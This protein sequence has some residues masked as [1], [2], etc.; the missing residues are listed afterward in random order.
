[1]VTT[2]LFGYNS[3]EILS[4]KE[5][6]TLLSAPKLLVG[7]ITPYEAYQL[8]K[9]GEFG[10]MSDEARSFGF[11][12]KPYW[13]AMELNNS[14]QRRIFLSINNPTLETVDCY[15]YQYGH[16]VE[17]LSD[18][19]FAQQPF[20]KDFSSLES[21]FLL[22]NTT[23][24]TTYLLKIS[25]NN[26]II[27]PML[28][29]ADG[30]IKTV[31]IPEILVFAI[32]TGC[33]LSLFLHNLMLYFS[34]KESDYLLYSAYILC[35]FIL[36]A[37]SR[38]Y[39]SLPIQENIAIKKI[40][41]TLAL[42]ATSISLILFTLKFLNI[43]NLH[44]KI[45][46]TS[47]LISTIC[48]L[49]LMP[50]TFD[51]TWHKIGILSIV[52]LMLLCIYLSIYSYL[53]GY[54]P[55]KHYLLGLFGIFA[56]IFLSILTIHG[57]VAYN[58]FTA[59]APLVSSICGMII[60]SLALGYKVK[61]LQDERN[62]AILRAHM[63]EK[64]LFLQ[65][66]YA[67]MGEMVGNIA[68][69]W[70]SPLNELGAI[71]ANIKASMLYGGGIAREKLITLQELSS[72][73]IKHLSDTIDTFYGFFKYKNNLKS[74]FSIKEELE[75]IQKML[76]YLLDAEHISLQCQID[77]MVLIGNKNEFSH[78]IINI[79]LNAKDAL[80]S[81]EINEPIIS[82][83]AY[84]DGNEYV[85]KISDNAGGIIENPIE[86]IFEPCISSKEDGIGIGLFISR[87]ILEDKMRAKIEVINAKLG[88]IFT[89]RLPLYN[90]TDSSKGGVID[91]M[92]ESVLDRM[93][94]LERKIVIKEEIE[95]MLKQWG[96]VFS[97]AHWGIALHPGTTDCFEMTNSAFEKMH[98][99]SSEELKSIEVPQLI[100]RDLHKVRA[101]QKEAFEKGF[102]SFET[103]SVRKDGTE[104]PVSVDITVV[105]NEIG[106]VL[107]YISNVR[108]ISEQK[109]S[110][111]NLLLK[112]TA[113]NNLKDGVYL[114][115]EKA[116]F[117][118]VNKGAC[119]SLGYNY[120]E[121]IK[122]R[123][124]DINLD[125]HE[126]DWHKLM[127]LR[128]MVQEVRHQKKDGSV[129]PVEASMN[130][131]E[132]DGKSF[133]MIIARDI[134]ERKNS[135]NILRDTIEKQKQYEE[136]LKRSE[137]SLKEVQKIAKIGSWRLDFPGL[138]L[139]YSDEMYSILEIGKLEDEISFDHLLNAVHPEDRV[140]VDMLFYASLI[141]KMPYSL[142]HRLLMP[143]GRVKYLRCHGEAC[144][145]A[146]GNPIHSIGTAQDITEQHRIEQK[147]EF[148]ARHDTL[149]QLPNR[150]FMK[151][152]AEQAIEYSKKHKTKMAI[153][154]IDIDDF[155]S[156]NDSLGHTVGD[157][158]LK[159]ASWRLKESLR[160]T[161]IIAR[162]GGDEFIIILSEIKDT[163]DISITADNIISSFK[164]PFLIDSL[165]LSSS[166]SMGISLY[167][168]DG[169]SFETLLQKADI[170]MYKAKDSGRNTYCFFAGHMNK[171][172]MDNLQIQNDLK[173]AIEKNEFILHYQP[174]VDLLSNT[175]SGVEALIRW[176][177]PRHGLISPVKFIPIAESSGSIVQIGAW[178]LHEACRQAAKWH[179][180]GIMVTMAVNISATQ[181]K[182]GDIEDV[183][184]MAVSLSGVSP[185]LL[186]LELTE[187]ILMNDAE[188][189]LQTVRNLKNMGL[190]LS[191]D[192]FGTGYSSLSYLKRFAVD[193]LKIDQS[194]V[195]GILLGQ[196]DSIIVNAVIQMA[197]NLNL[198]T[199]AE[200]VE[201]E[202]TLN[203]LSKHG[204]NE[205]QGY[206]FAKPMPVTEFE[207]FFKKHKKLNSH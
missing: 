31:T 126:D 136:E 176:K 74:Q 22:K 161:D 27:I 129:F 124:F 41:K 89:I 130:Y 108:D 48:I 67:S 206:Y 113:L 107:Y 139:T 7:D 25:S 123:V 201:D 39:I 14:S 192:D 186:E 159:A 185:E 3:I 167:P 92:E 179:S 57:F 52:I 175:I 33:F 30:D 135:E 177:H 101:K 23:A 187:S 76:K 99:Y 132:F 60:L 10:F 49:F 80:V 122:M 204:C 11:S 163:I 85:V 199:I 152:R 83:Q 58:V 117:H 165:M 88:A 109:N 68:H 20:D 205:V 143:D 198:K 207:R 24:P 37:S 112:K 38:E 171:E 43:N 28:I 131:I 21:R 154:F 64:M 71:Q 46:K 133:N 77:E 61:L 91:H 181:F 13:V 115:D 145:D 195:R 62:T 72:T 188:E 65:S 146:K 44:P 63:N 29:G 169:D 121:L 73:I 147:V 26:P 127:E 183:V 164:Q 78:A 97:L 153:L 17:T 104:F 191:I 180:K 168:N 166:I 137:A 190:K 79:I 110:Q 87:V 140:Q 56:G 116:T 75:N 120:S 70:R 160:G 106:D 128:S 59:I 203:V 19:A 4:D 12:N 162:Q 170:A 197:K 94:M 119:E 36:M 142:V 102:S 111:K 82:M 40:I 196:E 193:K 18:G 66:K 84:R 6:I 51:P 42:E 1:M 148:L 2:S 98:G 156:I 15:V 8:Y 50:M 105:K 184:R 86:Q 125:W 157:N 182:R 149:T 141:D 144:Y 16:L 200:G 96:N 53:D 55:T 95:K 34:T 118:Y 134:T 69:Q 90:V 151:D 158:M 189:I 32:F 54:G 138:K 103:T 100:A 174:Q 35:F 155:K 45:H 173:R 47:I 172:I 114:I 178:V 5:K 9:S 93:Y 81:R 194:F 150:L 202:Q